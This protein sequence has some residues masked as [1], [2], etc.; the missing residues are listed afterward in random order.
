M[1]ETWMRVASELARRS[2]CL[3]RAVGCVL[4]DGLGRALSTGYN[5][6]A[7]GMPHCNEQTGFNFVYADGVDETRPLTGQSTG[8]VPVFG[9]ACN[10]GEPFPAGADLCEAVHA[11]Q[12][13]LTECRDPDRIRTA[14]V[15]ASPCMRCAKQ[16]LNTGCRRVLFLEESGEEQARDL[17]L[18]AGRTW[19]CVAG[20]ESD[21]WPEG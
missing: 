7:R 17:W 12:N 9:H 15:T 1:D 13:A 2:T 6:T 18:R 19:L 4:T 14:Y 3:K 5:G 21:K 10:G 20:A 8:Q 16:L 11:E